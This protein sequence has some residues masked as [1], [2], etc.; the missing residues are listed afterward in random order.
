[1]TQF[2][3]R[4][5]ASIFNPS[6]DGNM[7]AYA[8]TKELKKKPFR[9]HSQI[10]KKTIGVQVTFI[11]EVRLQKENFLAICDSFFR[12]LRIHFESQ[13]GWEYAYVY[14]EL[15]KK[16][17]KAKQKTKKN[18]KKI[19]GLQVTFI[20]E[21]KLQKY[22]FSANVTVF[23]STYPSILNPCQDE[24]HC[25]KKMFSKNLKKINFMFGK[26]GNI[27]ASCFWGFCC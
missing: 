1:M 3:W 10:I 5:N 4:L 26:C 14:Q 9:I 6:Q 23:L 16:A 2:S 15:K 17:L 24:N 20:L 27:N 12:D 8:T 25:R 19:N 21:I 18:I 22:N 7:H 13:L 11:S